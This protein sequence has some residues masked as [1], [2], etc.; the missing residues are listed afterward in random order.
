MREKDRFLSIV[1]SD[2]FCS[3]G[4]FCKVSRFLRSASDFIN[5]GLVILKKKYEFFLGELIGLTLILNIAGSGMTAERVRIESNNF[6][7][8]S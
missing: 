4:A 1:S 3:L 7:S 2:F 5:S 8:F 6:M